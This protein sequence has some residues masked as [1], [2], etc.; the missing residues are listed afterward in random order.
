MNTFDQ[1]GSHVLDVDTSKFLLV[2]TKKLRAEPQPPDT[3]RNHFKTWRIEPQ[4]FDTTVF[5]QDQFMEDSLSLVSLEFLSN[6][7]KKIDIDHNDTFDIVRPDDHL[8]GYKAFGRD[9]VLQVEYVNQFE[10]TLY[11]I[12]KV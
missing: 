8:T 1:F 7:V 10:S 12:D 11:S 5:V 4:T 6:P 2:P 3:L 9:T